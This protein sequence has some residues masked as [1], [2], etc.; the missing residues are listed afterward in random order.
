M[1]V[2]PLCSGKGEIP[3]RHVH[4]GDG[5]YKPETCMVC[6]GTGEVDIEPTRK[7]TIV[8]IK[9]HGVWGVR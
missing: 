3:I 9:P 1:S 7:S 8:I 4:F 2:C 6:N 5:V